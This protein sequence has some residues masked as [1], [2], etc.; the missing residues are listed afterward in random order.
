MSTVHSHSVQY[1]LHQISSVSQTALSLHRSHSQS[2]LLPH[3]L[4]LERYHHT[5]AHQGHHPV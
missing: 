2:H 4:H 3:H 5:R 1:V